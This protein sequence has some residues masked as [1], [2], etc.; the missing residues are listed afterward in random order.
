MRILYV[1]SL[2]AGFEDILDGKTDSRGLPTFILP[3]KGLLDR[4]H[5]VDIILVSNYHRKIN[6]QVNWIK[7]ENIVLNINNNLTNHNLMS[8]VV[9]KLKSAIQLASSINQFVSSKHY[10][11]IYCHGTAGLVGNII[12]N[13]RHIPCGYRLYGTFDVYGTIQKMGAFRAIF[14]LPIYYMI[15]KLKKEFL[16]ITDDG[17]QGD[18]VYEAWK[19]KNKGKYQFIFRINGIDV[20]R[21]NDLQ[22]YYTNLQSPYIFMAGRVD[23]CK[24]QERSIKVL[25]LLHESGKR[26]HLYFAGHV[27]DEG[28][29]LELEK[30][31]KDYGL[32]DFVHFLGDVHR[33]QLKSLAYYSTATLLLGDISN[34]G[35]IFYEVYSTGSIVIGIN[36]GSLN[37][38]V[39]NGRTGFLV[40]DEQGACKVIEDILCGQYPIAEMRRL[41][42]E[43]IREILPSWDERIDFELKRIESCSASQG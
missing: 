9:N 5:Q 21:I 29:N 43:K 39:L 12:A 19:P 14:K 8:K 34:N 25:H 40:E 30:L 27:S 1:T 11:F 33:K 35:N 41:A 31:V 32:S 24:R 17:S 28:F 4:G 7:P 37:R 42:V 3:L 18:K 10:D 16:L 20:E 22:E 23:R 36:D 13:I 38:F 6:I 2:F 15:F 26:L